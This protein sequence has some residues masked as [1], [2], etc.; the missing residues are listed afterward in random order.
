MGRLKV[1]NKK[2]TW[3]YFDVKKLSEEDQGY[4]IGFFI[5]DGY[6][7]K[8]RIIIFA[9]SNKDVERGIDVKLKEIIA[10]SGKR[11]WLCKRKNRS[12]QLVTASK[13]LVAYFKLIVNFEDGKKSK[14]I[15]LKTTFHSKEFLK[16]LIAGLIDSDGSVGVA[17]YTTT[18]SSKLMKQIRE[19]AKKLQIRTILFVHFTSKGNK[20]FN[21]TFRNSDLKE[22]PVPSIKLISKS[23]FHKKRRK[24]L[25]ILD[26]VKGMPYEFTFSDIVNKT[27]CQPNLI[28]IL[29]NH[30]LIR[31]RN[32]L[33]KVSRGIY[34]KTLNF[35][36]QLINYEK[37]ISNYQGSYFIHKNSR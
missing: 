16:G 9:L 29:L 17:A 27:G 26:V 22:N 18:I 36:K 14:T 19:I 11:V 24:D 20:A 4:L 13:N 5:G 12:I 10:K 32:Y 21:V 31:R 8:G 23:W 7:K 30:R 6:I 15:H 37:I 25:W 3:S 2:W 34:K 28:W 1:N 35:E 33:E